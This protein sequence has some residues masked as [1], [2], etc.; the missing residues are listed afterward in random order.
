MVTDL[1]YFKWFTFGHLKF[2]NISTLVKLYASRCLVVGDIN[3][4]CY[5]AYKTFPTESKMYNIIVSL[6]FK[7]WTIDVAKTWKHQDNGRLCNYLPI[8]LWP[9][10]NTELDI[11]YIFLVGQDGFLNCDQTIL[12]S[13]DLML[14]YTGNSL[15]Q[16]LK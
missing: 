13:C 8:I 9:W 6:F 7:L 12:H 4:F 11:L 2:L 16:Q 10:H 14:S 1:V 15:N 3:M 5:L